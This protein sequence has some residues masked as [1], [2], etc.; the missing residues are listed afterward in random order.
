M[1]SKPNSRAL[2]FSWSS[3]QDILLTGSDSH[4][5][6][7]SNFYYSLEMDFAITGNNDRKVAYSHHIHVLIHSGM[8][9]CFLRTLVQHTRCNRNTITRYPLTT[10]NNRA[11]CEQWK[12]WAA[13]WFFDTIWQFVQKKRNVSASCN[14]T[15][16]TS[17]KI[18]RESSLKISS[19]TS[20]PDLKKAEHDSWQ[21]C[22]RYIK[23]N[24]QRFAKQFGRVKTEVSRGISSG[25]VTTSLILQLR[26]K[27][28]IAG[29]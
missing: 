23:K 26:G 18:Y 7:R 28:Q 25:W 14:K 22:N 3:A 16:N 2:A 29:I 9:C 20:K 12:Y 24:G 4:Q 1:L 5:S 10:K 11:Q 13:P 6:I 27:M 8:T 19:L 17:S 15:I 21:C